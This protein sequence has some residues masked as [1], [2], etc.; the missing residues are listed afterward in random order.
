MRIFPILAM[1]D[2]RDSSVQRRDGVDD[3]RRKLR[4]RLD[5]VPASWNRLRRMLCVRILCLNPQTR[6][7]N[8]RFGGR[9]DANSRQTRQGNHWGGEEAPVSS[10]TL[11]LHAIKTTA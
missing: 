3:R 2:Y 1:Y 6:K 9:P 4:L 11:G 5:K 7:Y 8:R 10:G